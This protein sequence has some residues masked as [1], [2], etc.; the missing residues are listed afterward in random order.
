[1]SN[2]TYDSKCDSYFDPKADSMPD[3]SDYGWCDIDASASNEA[4]ASSIQALLQ[5]KKI[6]GWFGTTAGVGSCDGL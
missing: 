1:M 4:D 6:E 5:E 2:E 3:M